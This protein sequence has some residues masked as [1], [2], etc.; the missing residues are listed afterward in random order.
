M[1][2][3]GGI[4]ETRPF[5]ASSSSP[6]GSPTWSPGRL[7]PWHSP[8]PGPRPAAV[9]GPGNR[10]AFSAYRTKNAHHMRPSGAGAAEDGERA[11]ADGELSAGLDGGPRGRVERAVRAGRQAVVAGSG[12]HRDSGAEGPD[13]PGKPEGAD[14]PGEP[15][16]YSRRK[17]GAQNRFPGFD[18]IGQS[19]HWDTVTAGLIA[20]RLGPQP[21][22]TFFT[23]GQEAC[24][25]DLLNLLPVRKTS[26]R[27]PSCRWSTPGW[28]PGKPTA[29]SGADGLQQLRPR[30]R[31]LDGALRRLA[32]IGSWLAVAG[33]GL[34]MVR[35]RPAVRR[36]QGFGRGQRARR[37]HRFQRQRFR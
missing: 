17:A 23:A 3:S 21:P 31:R 22:V 5:S 7:S 10:A 37:G 11:G 12:T 30:C 1:P 9:H 14:G 29:G 25:R 18:I 27:C 28:R 35:A 36:R 20:G 34:V 4:R 33:A 26:P 6:A 24:A 2:I 8:G 32:V 13:N 15:G 19:R 16:P